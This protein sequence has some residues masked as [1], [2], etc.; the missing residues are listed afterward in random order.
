MFMTEQSTPKTLR[1]EAQLTY[2]ID[3]N[4]AVQRDDGIHSRSWDELV[5]EP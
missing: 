1:L 3:G 2:F 4:V 5:A